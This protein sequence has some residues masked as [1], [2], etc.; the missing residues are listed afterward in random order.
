MCV[1]SHGDSPRKAEGNRTGTL[2]VAKWHGDVQDGMKRRAREKPAG[3]LLITPESLEALFVRRPQAL[4][5]MFE[6][7]DYVVVDELHT[8][9]STE[10]GLQLASL[11]RRL[12]LRVG[13]KPRRIGLSA[14]VGDTNVACQWLRPDDPASVVVVD[15]KGASSDIRLQIRGIEMPVPSLK[16]GDQKSKVS[17]ISARDIALRQISDHVFNTFR[18][19]GNHLVFA[20]S[21]REVELFADMLREQSASNKVQ[22][23]FFPHHGNL[24]RDMRETLEARLKGGSEPTTAVVSLPL[25]WRRQRSS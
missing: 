12:E 3:V 21:R 19:K 16:A 23:E 25:R 1:L 13:I 15:D 24:A 6:A 22:N 7:L 8:F 10:R 17:K 20:P 9:L 4:K 5:R 14:T 11:L 18:G 2:P